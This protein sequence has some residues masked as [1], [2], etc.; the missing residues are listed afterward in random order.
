MM[1]MRHPLPDRPSNSRIEDD[2][3]ALIPHARQH[4]ADHHVEPG[5]HV[6]GAV[7]LRVPKFHKPKIGLF[8]RDY[9]WLR[10]AD[11][12]RRVLIAA[13]AEDEHVF[14]FYPAAVY[15]GMRA[16]ELAAVEWR[17]ARDPLLLH[18]RDPQPYKARR[19]GR[20]RRAWASR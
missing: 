16:G 9:Q 20:T 6:H 3:P 19:N 4:P 14:V 13:R 5:D 18:A 2:R 8:S 17:G 11:E 10:S 12:I 15:T 1:V 7:L